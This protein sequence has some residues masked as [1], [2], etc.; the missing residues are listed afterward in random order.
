MPVKF[1]ALSKTIYAAEEGKICSRVCLQVY[2]HK[3]INPPFPKVFN[4]R[5]A[6]VSFCRLKYKNFKLL[7]TMGSW[8][9]K[10]EKPVANVV[11]K[12]EIEEQNGITFIECLMLIITVILTLQFI[13]KLYSIHK[14]T[15]KKKY[16]SRAM[17][18][19][20]LE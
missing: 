8:G 16:M 6:I 15:L 18:I 11:N 13:L 3:K 7:L 2:W 19:P 5:K 20:Q 9:S 12:V 10:V 17:S 14:K 1:R 4:L